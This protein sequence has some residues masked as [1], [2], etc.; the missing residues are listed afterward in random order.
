MLD[1]ITIGSRLHAKYWDGSF[2]AAEVLALS[3]SKRRTKAPIKVRYLGYTWDSDAWVSVVDLR[4]KSLQRLNKSGGQDHSLS[5]HLESLEPGI[6][7]QVLAEDGV[8]YAAEVIAGF[9]KR[10]DAVKVRFIGYTSDSDEWVRIDRIRSKVLKLHLSSAKAS[11]NKSKKTKISISRGEFRNLRS[12]PEVPVILA[13]EK[14]CCVSVSSITL[15]REIKEQIFAAAGIPT[16]CQVL[17]ID[18]VALMD[19]DA[20]IGDLCTADSIQLVEVHESGES[21]MSRLQNLLQAFVDTGNMH[22]SGCKGELSFFNIDMLED[23]AEET[24]MGADWKKEDCSDD[25]TKFEP[26]ISLAE[27]DMKM[28]FPDVALPDFGANALQLLNEQGATGH[29]CFMFSKR[30]PWGLEGYVIGMG[31]VTSSRC[32][33]G[34]EQNVG[35]L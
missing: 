16:P 9:S 4:S 31:V 14:L 23:T 26:K 7:L 2:Y 35:W 8:W 19:D 22:Y 10:R 11:Q 18:P 30:D 15:V 25:H 24:V 20:P 21:V 1:C 28:W 27:S 32:V 6:K 5:K 29:G 12:M 3:D 34:W 13:G 17:V 33:V